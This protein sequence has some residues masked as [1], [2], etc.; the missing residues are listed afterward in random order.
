MK[1]IRVAQFGGPEVLKVLTDVSIPKPNVKE[2]RKRW[3]GTVRYDIQAP[4]P[5]H[6]AFAALEKGRSS[7][8]FLVTTPFWRSESERSARFSYILHCKHSCNQ[9]QIGRSFC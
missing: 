6:K 9:R 8:K 2:V 3:N 5:N 7:R 1:A 4:P